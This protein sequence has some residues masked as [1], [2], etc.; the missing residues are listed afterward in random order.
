MTDHFV[1]E[2]R[3]VASA[4]IILRLESEDNGVVMRRCLT[5]AVALFAASV[6]TAQRLPNIPAPSDVA[7]PPA[8]A[9][10]TPS[11]LVS[12][13][14]MP[15]TGTE[16][17]R[18]IDFVTVQYTGWTSEGQFFDEFLRAQHAEPVRVESRHGRVGVSAC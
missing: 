9:L 8:E 11:G 14:V 18:E 3:L 2:R 4:G 10:T 15:G 13:I 5:T 7:S 17:P 16:T 12:R 1:L 6:A